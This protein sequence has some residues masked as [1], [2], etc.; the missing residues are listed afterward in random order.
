MAGWIDG[1]IDKVMDQI[2]HWVAGSERYPTFEDVQTLAAEVRDRLHAVVDRLVVKLVNDPHWL[3]RQ[4][5]GNGQSPADA[6]VSLMN[7]SLRRAPS[8]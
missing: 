6:T 7:L 5:P 2:I 1:I 8:Q 3:P 4:A